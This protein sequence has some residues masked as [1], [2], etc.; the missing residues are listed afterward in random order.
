MLFGSDYAKNNGDGNNAESCLV[1][2]YFRFR[3]EERDELLK[4]ISAI[5]QKN[6]DLSKNIKDLET[7]IEKYYKFE[8]INKVIKPTN[9]NS[10]KF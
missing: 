10:P 1:K 2:E 9:S 4:I 8:E 6:S 5:L 7:S 3:L